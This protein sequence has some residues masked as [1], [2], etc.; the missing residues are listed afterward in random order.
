[1]TTLHLLRHAHAGDASTWAGPDAT[2]PL[3]DKGRLQAERLGRFLDGL[4][5]VP[6]VVLSS[7][8]TRAMETARIVA[9]ILGV[10]MRV[11][12]RLGEMVELDTLDA[13]L[14]DHGDPPLPVLVGHDPD[15]TDLLATLCGADGVPMR[16]GSFARIEAQ[17]PLQPGGGTLR[18]LVPPDL[19]KPER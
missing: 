18:W 19:L 5:F 15:F 12:E 9:D 17:R 3:T 10:G 1:M 16:K 6:D 8:K 14:A 2:R 7:P 11:E 4:G 13:I